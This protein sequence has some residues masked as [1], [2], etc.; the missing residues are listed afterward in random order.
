MQHRLTSIVDIEYGEMD[1]I[2]GIIFKDAITVMKRWIIN[3]QD[4]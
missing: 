4:Q 3:Y 2:L 1:K